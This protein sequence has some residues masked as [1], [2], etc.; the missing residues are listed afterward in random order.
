MTS[1]RS[2]RIAVLPGDGIGP[3]VVD[4]AIEVA[5]AAAK[6]SGF[7]L[8]FDTY[9]IGGAA[10]DL[11]G[12]PLS[13]E[14][15]AASRKAD[16][17][18]LGAVGGPKWDDVP[19]DIRP[20]QGLL[21]LRKALG[22][23]ANLRPVHVPSKLA[24]YS[25]LENKVVADVDIL[26]VRE[27]T[28]GIYFGQ[29]R[30]RFE[31]DGVVAAHDTMV[32]ST[33]EIE[34][35][36]RVA[37]EAALKRSRSVTSVDKAN[38]LETSRLWRE[39]VT[40]I[41]ASEF[42][43]VELTHEYVDA[44]AMRLI[45]N[46]T[47]FDVVVTGNLFGDILSDLCATLPG[48]IGLLP[49]ASIGNGAGLFEPVHGSAPDIAGLGTANPMATILSMAMLFDHLGE[50]DSARLIRQAI[51]EALD[52]GV[53]SADLARDAE[54]IS[55]TRQITEFVVGFVASGERIHS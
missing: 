21:R 6:R 10:I 17:V 40:R 30:G 18:L 27:L 28:G 55:T 45:T 5:R 9:P 15:I 16:A 35:V 37:F 12:S 29:P 51:R 42:P 43:E 34:R 1:L 8:Q 19:S 25:P 2:Y 38:V 4:A 20:E 46:P 26:I 33:H 14:T 50:I 31:V 7:S 24:D 39:T 44:A 54:P 36:A 3:E 41:G 48:T 52:T 11:H 22:V 23:F 49:S 32:Y 13:Q 47:D 53:V